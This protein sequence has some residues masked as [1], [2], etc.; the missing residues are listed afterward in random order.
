MVNFTRREASAIMC[1][2]LSLLMLYHSRLSDCECWI[3]VTKQNASRQQIFLVLFIG[4]KISI[5]IYTLLCYN[6]TIGQTSRL[7]WSTLINWCLLVGTS[8]YF[9]IF[10][11]LLVSA[12]SNTAFDCTCFYFA[13]TQRLF[14]TTR[15]F[16]KREMVAL[17]F[18]LKNSKSP[19]NLS[20][21]RIHHHWKWTRLACWTN[22]GDSCQHNKNQ[23]RGP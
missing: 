20:R 11:F 21:L 9:I 12:S 6:R 5:F 1:T 14:R 3:N 17:C 8:N 2:V 18:N 15:H 4:M 7:E 16:G 23:P 13:I 22:K 19:V 10:D